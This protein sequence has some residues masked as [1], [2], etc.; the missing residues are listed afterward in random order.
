MRH[1]PE[2]MTNSEIHAEYVVLGAH[3][4]SRTY[5]LEDAATAYKRSAGG[6]IGGRLVLTL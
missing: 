6:G 1:A 5:A 2:T 4:G 3:E